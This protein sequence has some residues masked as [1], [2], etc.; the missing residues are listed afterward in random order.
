[1][2]QKKHMFGRKLLG[3]IVAAAA[4]SVMI[5]AANAPAQAVTTPGAS[6][7]MTTHNAN[8]YAP[9]SITA[10]PQCNGQE[11]A[12]AKTGGG[13]T[14]QPVVLATENFDCILQTGNNS[15]GVAALQIALNK[16]HNYHLTVDGKFGTA[17]GQA[18]LAVQ[19]TIGVTADGVYGPA[20]RAKMS[21]PYSGG[22]CKRGSEYYGS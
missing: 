9:N 4:A 7:E 11:S 17:T 21:W 2:I 13:Y 6:A 8:P 19:R 1:M 12:Y 10:L 22:G 5:L 16:C 15:A 14:F 3:G 20:T 18:L